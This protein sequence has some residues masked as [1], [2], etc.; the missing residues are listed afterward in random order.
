MAIENFIAGI[1]PRTAF[2]VLFL[3]ALSA[4]LWKDRNQIQR[5]YIL[6]YRRTKKGLNLI[7]RI[8]AR[9]PRFWKY[10]G[11]AAV[12]TGV[13]SI[14]ASFGLTA[15]MFFEMF[16]TQT[17]QNGP[18]LIAPGLSGDVSFQPGVSF[19]PIEYWLFA[20]GILSVV[21]EFSHGIVARTEG[22]NL[23]SVGWAIFG[24]FPAAFVEPEGEQMLPGEEGDGDEDQELWHG[25][26]WYSRLKVLCAGSFANYLTAAVFV[27]LAIG[28]STGAT[29]PETVGYMGISFGLTDGGELGYAAQEGYPAYES[30][31]RNGTLEAING[32]NIT[33]V[34][35]LQNFSEGLQPNQ[36]VT[37][38][39]S[40]GTFQFQ[41]TQNTVSRLKEGLDQ[42][43]GFLNWFTTGLYTVGMLNLLI[44]L[45]NMLPIKPLDGG[46][47]LEALIENYLGEDRTHWVNKL[48]LAM[49]ALLLTTLA[50][51]IGSSVI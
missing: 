15:Q 45:F 36:S 41:T 24:I 25:G 42:Y 4:F 33:S 7:D 23:N 19:I 39:T 37:L 26:N 21:H 18:S 8:A 6:F 48:S 16:R 1:N 32:Q 20:I 12:V 22:F 10:Y 3:G 35:D 30:G 17:M 5:H 49:W 14:A 43:A 31:L 51:T 27:L 50:V 9:A 34:D 47:A 2:F 29:T 38:E 46:W 28:V 13:I 44:G 40:E 11:A